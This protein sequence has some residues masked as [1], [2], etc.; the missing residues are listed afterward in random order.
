MTAE[1]L[2]Q[3]TDEIADAVAARL[4]LPDDR[5]LL[6]FQQAAERISVSERTVRQLIIDGKL[7]SVLISEGRRVVEPAE[8]DRYIA[9][10]RERRQ[11]DPRQGGPT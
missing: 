9:S 11:V 8:L 3:L 1:Y 5:P 10:K 7:G 6:T 2:A 4:N